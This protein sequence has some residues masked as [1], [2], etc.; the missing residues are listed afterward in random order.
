MKEGELFL[1]FLAV[2]DFTACAMEDPNKKL[3]LNI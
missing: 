2:F 1:K 3:T